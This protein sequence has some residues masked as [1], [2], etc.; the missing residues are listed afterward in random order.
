MKISVYIDKNREEEIQIF[1]HNE[2]ELIEQIKSLVN[3][4]LSQINGFG[5]KKRFTFLAGYDMILRRCFL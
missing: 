3:E 4:S 1:A 2:S 5:N